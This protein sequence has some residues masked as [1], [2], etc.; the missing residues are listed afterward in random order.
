MCGQTAKQKH[1]LFCFFADPSQQCEDAGGTFHDGKYCY[2][3]KISLTWDAANVICKKMGMHL[4][5][6]NNAAE[7]TKIMNVASPSYIVSTNLNQF[8]I[9]R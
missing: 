3:I 5:T 8:I 7:N 2:I 6:I 1:L 9:K 4:A